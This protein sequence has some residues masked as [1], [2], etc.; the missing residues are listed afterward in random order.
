MITIEDLKCCGN[1]MWNFRSSAKCI[2]V[3]FNGLGN[4]DYS[5]DDL[6]GNWK[7]DGKKVLERDDKYVSNPIPEPSK[8]EVFDGN[9]ELIGWFEPKK[10]GE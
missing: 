6:C 1:C 8:Q 5:P 9:G 3:R 7:Y 2:E 4:E 10:G